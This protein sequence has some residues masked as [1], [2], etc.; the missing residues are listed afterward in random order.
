[1]SAIGGEHEGLAPRLRDVA[2]AAVVVVFVLA[3]ALTTNLTMFLIGKFPF[4]QDQIELP[5][6]VLVQAAAWI[7][8]GG[9]ALATALDGRQ[10]RVH[11][12]LVP[13]GAFLLIAGV[14]TLLS[15]YMFTALFGEYRHYEG[16]FTLL[17][18]G[19]LGFA[20]MQ[21]ST[22]RRLM[23]LARLSILTGLGQ[24][25]YGIEQTLHL[26]SA[27]WLSNVLPG[28]AFATWGNPDFFAGYLLF[29]L[30]FSLAVAFADPD[31]RWRAAGGLSAAVCFAAIIATATRGAWVACGVVVALMCVALIRNGY[32]WKRVGLA[33]AAVLVA[34][35]VLFNFASHGELLN[36]V[37]TVFTSAEAGIG[38]QRFGIWG[39]AL[40]SAALHP[41]LGTGPD[42]LA[43]ASRAAYGFAFSD[44]AH[45]YPLQLS[46][47]V[48]VFAVIALYVFFVWACLSSRKVGFSPGKGLPH[49]ALAATWAAA[50]GYL[51]HTLA[52]VS[53]VTSTAMLFVC[54]GVLLGAATGDTWGT[55]RAVSATSAVLAATLLVSTLTLGGLAIAADHAYIEARI[56]ARYGGDRLT[57]AERAVRLN[58]LNET[59]ARE[60]RMATRAAGQ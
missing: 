45:D 50:V 24:A 26:D 3:P 1:M 19:A 46:L 6:V 41:L 57:W 9:W 37:V 43:P 15:P 11:K 40:K 56:A 10:V 8:L 52:G 13:L 38:Y 25:I 4:T 12:A 2:W 59:Y 55:P 39:Y 60:L 33:A 51:T 18:Y 20:A 23:W 48:G 16:F 32:P 36:R 17:A 49:L 30:A 53:M 7:A 22:S 58:G 14:S 29:P 47:T 54:V 42:T 31:R 27:N 44:D 35:A 28:R 5:R 21:L 34:S